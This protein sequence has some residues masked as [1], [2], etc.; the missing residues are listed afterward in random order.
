[1]DPVH[2]LSAD[3]EVNIAPLGEESKNIKMGAQL[4]DEEI[5]EYTK[6]FW[7]F[8][9]VLAWSYLDLKGIP[10]DITEHQIHLLLDARP[11]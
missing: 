8:R 11:I 6:L 2:V 7:E 1:M 9:E 4:T 10:L 3:W 5:I